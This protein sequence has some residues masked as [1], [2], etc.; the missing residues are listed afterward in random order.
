MA[1]SKALFEYL[2]RLADD[3]LI[4]GQRLGEWCGHGP[5]LEEDLALTNIALDLIGQARSLY[6]Y[7]GQV[8]GKGRDEDQLAFL[9]V[10]RE[11]RNALLMEQ[12]NGDFAHTIVRQ[13]FHA[14]FM[15]PFWREMKN[16]TDETLAGIA[17]KAEK[18]LQYHLRHVAEWAIRLGDGT[19]ESRTRMEDAL[20]DL[21]MYSGELF[22]MDETV[23]GLAKAGTAIDTAALK[24]E[25]DRIVGEVLAEA[26]L[27]HPGERGMQTG[28]RSGRHTEH[29]GHILSELQ[30]MQRTYPNLNW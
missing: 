18:E 20:D 27:E 4:L 9:R 10:E 28:G 11:Y 30:Y 14:A 5:T 7:A 22:E 26:T 17:A 24:P 25:W 8:E 6:T 23:R 13:L 21:W 2:I 29:M 19:E 3:Q 1:D 16:S 15:L 12:P